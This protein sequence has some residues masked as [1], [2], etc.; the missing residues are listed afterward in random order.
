M[1]NASCGGSCNAMLKAQMLATALDVFFDDPAMANAN[2]DLTNICTGVTCSASENDS[3]AFG[4]AASLTVAQILGYAASQSN[5]GGSSW[6][7]N[8]KATQIM[9][10]MFSRRSAAR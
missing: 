9:A 3:G 7:G 5:P 2:V 10:R 4:G 8:V 6:Y 1:N